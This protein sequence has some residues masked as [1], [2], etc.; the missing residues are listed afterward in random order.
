MSKGVY[1]PKKE[2]FDAKLEAYAKMPRSFASLFKLCFS[3]KENI[4]YER[5]E[6]YRIVKTTYGEAYH[7]IL[8]K[9]ASV[10][11][12]LSQHEYNSAVGLYM[13]NNLAYIETFWAV[14][15]AGFRP[16]LLNMHLS[17]PVLDKA[18]HDCCAAAVISDAKQFRVET[19]SSEALSADGEE[20]VPSDFGTEILL[21][22]SGT[23]QHVKICAYTAE[24]LYYLL[25][26]TNEILKSCKAMAAHYKGR[27]KIL[28]LL[29]FYHIFGLF[30]VYIW[31]SFF[32]RTFV[33]LN[34]MTPQTVLDTVRRHKVTHIFAVPLFWNKIY[35]KALK[36]IKDKGEKTCG[37]FS[38]GIKT[39]DRIGDIPVI[40][41]LYSKIAFKNVRK[42]LFGDSIGFMITGGG[43][44]S[45]QVLAFFNNIGYRLANGYGITEVGI[46]SVELSSKKRYLNGGFVGKPMP[47]LKYKI[48]KTG[49]LTVQGK[50][51]SSYVIENGRRTVN[52]GWYNTGDLAACEDGHYLILGRHDDIIIAA[53]GENLNPNLIEPH[54]DG[55]TELKGVCIIGEK[56]GAETVPVML[57]SVNK[58][59]TKERFDA[60]NAA[61]KDRIITLGLSQLL[62]KVVYISE[63]LLQGKEFKLNRAR[64]RNDYTNGKLS[65]LLPNPKAINDK[66]DELFEQIREYFAIALDKPVSEIGADADFFLDCGGTS[67]DYFALISKIQEEFGI[68]LTSDLNTVNAMCDYIRTV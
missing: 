46:A 67:L 53:N 55:I 51:I 34:D 16:L 63:P 39:A 44:I 32:S 9:A 50:G 52:N 17:D 23:M 1:K 41:K 42:N 57:A 27:L 5:S 36:A 18:L 24:N 22:S 4:M 10:R 19:I 30:A 6:G 20:F 60:L 15:A 12:L 28:T 62:R 26:G 29:P 33:Q 37:K 14:L 61:I 8:K 38:R 43:N 3:E 68:V 65:I 2:F 59:I 49:E 54:F 7:N 31:F 25:R 11:R 58:Y 40:G 13:D 64:L 66:G 35:E 47:F 45:R 21:M 48:N 56:D